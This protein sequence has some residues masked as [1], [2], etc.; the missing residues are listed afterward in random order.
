[1]NERRRDRIQNEHI[2]QLK[3]VRSSARELLA[4]HRKWIEARLGCALSRARELDVHVPFDRLIVE[5]CLT[6]VKIAPDS[7][8]LAMGE[9]AVPFADPGFEVLPHPLLQLRRVLVTMRPMR[10]R[11]RPA[12]TRWEMPETLPLRI[13][14]DPWHDRSAS[15]QE[16]ESGW[17]ARVSDFLA[18]VWLRGIERAIVTYTVSFVRY[19]GGPVDDQYSALLVHPDD[20]PGVLAALRPCFVMHQ[21]GR[22]VRVIGGHDQ[23]LPDD[24]YDWAKAVLDEATLRGIR[25]D[26]DQFLTREEWFRRRRLRY[27]RGYLLYGPPGN[28]K[29]TVA[30]IIACHPTLSAFTLDFSQ[31][32]YGN[33]TLTTLFEAASRHAPALVILEDLDRLYGRRSRDVVDAPDNLTHITLQHLLNCLD[34]W[35][36]AH[37]VVVVGTANDVRALDRALL[38]PG[39]FDQLIH[40][41]PPSV[42]LRTAYLQ[43]LDV[44]NGLSPELVGDAARQSEGLSF[45]QLC[46]AYLDADGKG[47][48]RGLK[49]D[50][51]NGDDLLAAIQSELR[52]TRTNLDGR[53]PGFKRDS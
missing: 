2:R 44:D 39:R 15:D 30:N 22:L 10:A 19:E 34:G 4:S 28:G 49:K 43:R 27:R 51:I 20:L 31:P 23:L 52:R 6:G 47:R 17:R 35:S 8:D 5:D 11:L 37:G 26:L 12:V 50:E 24:G 7:A 40:L 33:D 14:L 41:G 9:G 46:E 36:T 21:P 45:A 16:R 48:A 32:Q 18:A 38:R 53:P 25:D 3:F 42:E 29:T 1:M 13:A